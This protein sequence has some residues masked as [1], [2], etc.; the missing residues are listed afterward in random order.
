MITA[1]LIAVA[2]VAAFLGFTKPG[3][4]L[5]YQLGFTGACMGDSCN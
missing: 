4:K 3:H 5:L 2:L 1:V